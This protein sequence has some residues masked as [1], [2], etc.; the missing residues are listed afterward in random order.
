MDCFEVADQIIV[1]DGAGS[2]I[3]R[4]IANLDPEFRNMLANL[5]SPHELNPEEEEHKQLAGILR[6]RRIRETFDATVRQPTMQRYEPLSGVWAF[7]GKFCK[8]WP[9][10]LLFICNFL[11]ASEEI[12]AGNCSI[13]SPLARY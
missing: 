4:T 13:A 11:M 12:L 3:M 2:A 5:K 8:Q 1:F 10:I 7:H 6:S 9:T